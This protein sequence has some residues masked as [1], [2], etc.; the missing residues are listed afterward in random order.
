MMGVKTNG[1]GLFPPATWSG[2]RS[3]EAFGGDEADYPGPRPA[4][5]FLIQDGRV[6]G[7][8]PCR[9]GWRRRDIGEPIDLTGR[10]LVLA[11]GS[12]LDPRKLVRR[13]PHE[14]LMALRCAIYDYAAVWCD[15][16]RRSGD[17][18][19]TLARMPGRVEVHGL[20]A[21]T[22]KQLHCV[23]RWE[24]NP[25]YYQRRPF[26]ARVLVEDGTLADGV[27]AY[28]GTPECRPPLRR[29]G[30]IFPL[31]EHPYRTI[32]AM[33]PQICKGAEWSE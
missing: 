8:D 29:D 18:V 32:D 11:Y 30:R 23:D 20:L 25:D 24:G 27:T 3:P 2:S 13:L 31:A 14:A 6:Y 15:A 16:R 9:E 12:N 10:Q 22:P 5:S 33:V 4:G 17:V 21:L 1:A 28:F 26:T 19:A 7:L